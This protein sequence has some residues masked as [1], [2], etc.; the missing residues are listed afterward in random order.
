V[1]EIVEHVKTFDITLWKNEENKFLKKLIR[2]F[3]TNNIRAFE[4]ISIN[5]LNWNNQINNTKIVIIST[6]N[7]NSDS[8]YQ[9]LY[10]TCETH[11]LH[12]TIISSN[13][14]TKTI[15]SDNVKYIFLKELYGVYY[16]PNIRT[17]I[18]EYKNL[19]T[20][21]MQR[22]NYPRLKL[23]LDL[24]KN[25]LL[26]RGNVSLLGFNY[27]NK[28]ANS[29][30]REILDKHDIELD[31]ELDLPFKNFEDKDSTY[32]VEQQS[33]YNIVCESYN[34]NA[35]PE[36]IGFSEKT[37]RSL[38]IPNITLMLNKKGSINILSDLG[39]KT[40]KINCLLDSLTDY[41][42]QN[43]FIISAL[44]NDYCEANEVVEFAEHNALI[45]KKYNERINSDVFINEIVKNI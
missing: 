25:N 18:K 4:D 6:D 32:K 43:D 44:E 8:W 37:F 5:F 15:E 11:N 22:T 40:H 3:E 45:L 23:F 14:L 20:C 17:N 24:K 7:P 1:D 41:N 16:N 9:D 30:L 34:D 27:D 36:C 31:F 2:T 12:A 19:Y 39:F 33:K 42:C 13:V 28:T 29:V 26:Q 38:Q 21:L 10:L 35:Y